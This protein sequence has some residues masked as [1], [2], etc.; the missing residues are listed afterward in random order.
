METTNEKT[1]P[2]GRTGC[3]MPG[4]PHRF[5]VQCQ[6]LHRKV[7]V[8]KSSF[9]ERS[10]PKCLT[11]GVLQRNPSKASVRE[12]MC[13]HRDLP[14]THRPPNTAAAFKRWLCIDS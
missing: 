11:E 4:L 1:N 10:S 6:V 12:R 13:V 3:P 7:T 9:L 8:Q 14:S 5:C 2:W